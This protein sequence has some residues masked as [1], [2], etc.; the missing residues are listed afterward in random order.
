MNG[1]EPHPVKQNASDLERQVPHVCSCMW[2]LAGKARKEEENEDRWRRS[3][4]NREGG[5]DQCSMYEILHKNPLYHSIVM[6]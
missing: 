1:T 3:K 4:S 2:N 6:S 5:Y